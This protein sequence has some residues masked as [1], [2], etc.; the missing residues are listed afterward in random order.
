MTTRRALSVALILA[1]GLAILVFVTSYIAHGQE[2]RR[3]PL[4]RTRFEWHAAPAENLEQ[5]D[6]AEIA[7]ARGT[8]DLA[9]YVLTDWAIMDALRAAAARGIAVRIILD[10][11]QFQPRNSA[12]PF[13]RLVA[14][15]NVALRVKPSKPDIMHLKAW[16]IDGRLLR[17][18]SA[19]FSASGEKRQNNDLV[20]TDNPEAIA[21]F[22]R[23]FEAIWDQSQ[24][25]DTAMP[26]GDAPEPRSRER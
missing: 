13:L 26:M 12:G 16:A 25:A 22:D 18:G 17:T 10:G 19:N 20:L 3:E 11:S 1:F 2:A 7:Q 23:T 8:I 6:I 5:I 15:P 4:Q 14:E 24:G 9:A 21:A